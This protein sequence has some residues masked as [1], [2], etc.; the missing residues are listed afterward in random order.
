MNATI[1][2]DLAVDV[3]FAQAD[4]AE[5]EWLL[6][7]LGDQIASIHETLKVGAVRHAENMA[8]FVTRRLQTTI[9]QY[10]FLH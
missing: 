3:E 6:V 4:G 1:A 9:S 2:A 7:C 8:D 10:L 5:R